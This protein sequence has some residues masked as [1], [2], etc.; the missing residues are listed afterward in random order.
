MRPNASQPHLFKVPYVSL[1]A[2]AAASAAFRLGAAFRRGSALHY[3][4]LWLGLL[5]MIGRKEEELRLELSRLPL[6]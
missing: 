1:A 5:T 6:K 2:A 3:I 4:A